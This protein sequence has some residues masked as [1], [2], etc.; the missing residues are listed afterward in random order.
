MMRSLRWITLVSAAGSKPLGWTLYASSDEL[1]GGPDDRIAASGTVASPPGAASSTGVTVSGGTWPSEAGD[2]YLLVE[3]Y[4]ADDLTPGNNRN[5]SA[6]DT[7]IYERLSITPAVASVYTGQEIDFTVSGGTGSYSYLFTQ[8][9]SGSPS[10]T[11]DLYTAGA[12]P[13]IDILE[14]SDDLFP[15]WPAA[16]ATVTVASTPP[17]PAGDVEYEVT[18][19]TSVNPTPAAGSSIGEFFTIQNTGADDGADTLNWAVYLSQNNTPG[20]TAGDQLI[21]TDFRAPL[22]GDDSAPGG[23]DEATFAVGGN[24]PLT[25]GTRYLKVREWADDETAS[26]QWF[27]SG[28]FVVQ[29][30]TLDIDYMVS[31]APAGGGYQVGSAINE[32]FVVENQGSDAGS[33]DIDWYVYSSTDP[34][35]NAGDT[36]IDS[37][38]Y[39]GGLG[40]GGSTGIGVDG[41]LV[42]GTWPAAGSYYLIVRLEAAD[43]TN[44]SNNLASSALYTIA[45][46]V[47]TT[48]DYLAGGVSMYAPNVTT[49]SSVSETFTIQNIGSNGVDEVDWTAYA[50]LDTTPDA[51]EEIGSG[52][53]SALTAGS[54]LAGITA[55]GTWPTTPGSYYL[56]IT[57]TAPDEDPADRPDLGISP[58]RF[59]VADPPDYE[60]QGVTFPLSVEAGTAI[61]GDFQIHNGGTGDGKRNIR[62]EAF[63]SYDEGFSASDLLLGSGEVGALAVGNSVTIDA[64]ELDLPDW[65]NY[66]L[67][68][69]LIRI[70]ADDD[71]AESND[72]YVSPVREIYLV[73][74]EGADNTGASNDGSGRSVGAISPAQSV[75]T[76]ERGQTLV[77]KG[78]LDDSAPSAKYDTYSF[79]IGA[80]V[81][82]VSTFATWASGTDI[83]ALNL[84]D[85]FDNE[86]AST[87]NTPD[88]EPTSNTL[89]VSGW[90]AAEVGYVGIESYR[91]VATGNEYPYAIYLSGD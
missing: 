61:G 17:P 69:L 65:P 50:S 59:T 90:V 42:G 38:S 60:V 78:W 91:F 57:V 68:Y 25:A 6:G 72:E 53:I 22:D 82:S 1:I 13:G 58:A 44:S 18:S 76:L 23:S 33:A 67:S 79:I 40:F 8:S 32:S 83:G 51:G 46:P 73:D 19:F 39:P 28:A 37:G 80:G 36:L 20:F 35:Y 4:A 31:T 47:A 9:N 49:G 21:D 70:S 52:T 85:E 26:D 41:D 66:G 88:R 27:A 86:F 30:S 81:T 16:N 48:P 87:D 10:M 2:Y 14:V 12:S 11:G 62:W 71:G 64:S 77:I 7:S 55:F 89:S 29:L 54:S 15:A 34:F 63:L 56:I 84:W 75:G 3:V 74:S 5:Q 45:N 43:E 24:W